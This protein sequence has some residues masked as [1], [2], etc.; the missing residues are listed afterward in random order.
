VANWVLFDRIGRL[1]EPLGFT[2]LDELDALRADQRL[3]P[4]RDAVVAMS[5]GDVRLTGWL[6]TGR[7]VLPT[8]WWVHET[9]IPLMVLAGLRAYTFDPTV[10]VEEVSG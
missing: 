2:L 6:Q 1:R 8:T 3:R 5:G 10:K 7:G 9:G 4:Y